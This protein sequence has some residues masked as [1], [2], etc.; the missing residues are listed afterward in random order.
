MTQQLHNEYEQDYIFDVVVIGGGHAA[1]EAALACARTGH[2]TCM[3]ILNLESIGLLACNPSIGGT[4]KGHLVREIDALGGQMGIEADKSLI[5]L[6]MLNQSKGAA[7]QSL[8][9]QID[10]NRY[11][12]NMKSTLEHTPN[13]R[14]RQA[15]AVE[16]IVE[17][18]KII[19][20]KTLFGQIYYAKAVIVATGV[21]LKSHIIIGDIIQKQG[22]SGFASAEHLSDS[23]NKIGHNTRRFK[24][25]TPP[26]VNGKSIDYSKLEIQNGEPWY[27]FSVMSESVEYD[28]AP[29]YLGYT[30]ARTHQIIRENIHLAP[31]YSGLIEGIGARY[32]PAIEDKVMR[33][34][35]KERHQF[36]LEPEGLD[37][38]EVYLQGLSTSLPLDIQE[39]IIRSIEGLEN[40]QIMRDAYA[41][42]YECIDPLTLKPTLESKIIDGLY[43]AGQ[44]NGSSG[45]EEA[46][47]QGLMAGINASLKLRGKEPLVLR[48]DQAYIGVLIDD[49]TTKGTNEPYRMMTS[50]AE[51]RLHLRQD[52]ADLRLTQ[53]GY[54]VGL[55]TK[56]RYQK[57]LD[58]LEQIQK[59]NSLLDK[60]FSP[61]IINPLL[62]KPLKSGITLKELFK[63]DD[64]SLSQIAQLDELKDFS[65]DVIR[66]V[67]LDARYEGYIAR[68]KRSIEEAQ[69]LEEFKLPE[70]LN[71]N[72]LKG[73][74]IEAR[75][76]LQKIRPLTLGQASRISGVNPADINV[77][78]L[79]IKTKK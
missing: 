35:D 34:K 25:G 65:Y 40:A 75:Q 77:L 51:F 17:N 12:T 15:E 39:K 59:L 50:R 76:K 1:S 16:L 19:G 66:Q 10:K 29:C 22:P 48:R 11:H 73:L 68:M 47:A 46:A 69:K 32:C 28:R 61:K 53:I 24:T 26:R 9:A 3:L 5:Q 62:N 8:R 49:L 21:Y 58:K 27:A 7:V 33:F 38:V 43:F 44:I 72:K 74:R 52:N 4:S 2:K 23:I 42:E 56:E 45:Y 18:K 41:I 71:Y 6:R 67:S 14:L 37:T 54:D 60:T 64:L 70:D 55:A 36:F 79:Y 31:M 63:R 78:L 13:L 30:N 20:V 57:Y